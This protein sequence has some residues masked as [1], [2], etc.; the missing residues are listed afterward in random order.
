M[1]FIFKAS[2]VCRHCQ[3][4]FL[5][6]SPDNLWSTFQYNRYKFSTY[7]LTFSWSTLYLLPRKLYTWNRDGSYYIARF[8]KR[9]SLHSSFS[10]C[11]FQGMFSH[12]I[13]FGQFLLIFHDI[14]VCIFSLECW[15]FTSISRCHFENLLNVCNIEFFPSLLFYT[16][17]TQIL[18]HNCTTV[19]YDSLSMILENLLDFISSLSWNQFNLHTE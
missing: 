14:Y 4:E 8:W 9:N 7:V 3:L 16:R 15:I 10:T 11:T 1:Y 12:C 18:W 6:F 5:K 19:R 2:C 13:V 17:N